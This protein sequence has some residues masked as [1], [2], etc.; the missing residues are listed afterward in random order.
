MFAADP[1]APLAG[2]PLLRWAFV[3]LTLA[4]AALFVG[5]VYWSA[6]RSNLT[7]DAA[8]RQARLAALVALAWIVATGAAAA[9]GVLKFQPPTIATVGIGVI[10]LTI[11]AARHPLGRRLAAALPLSA[12]VGFQSFRI[13]VELLLH[14][15]YTEGL[16]PVQMSYSGRNFDV[17]SGLTAAA[18]AL[19]L[20]TGRR[21]G[22]RRIVFLWNTLGVALLANILI[23]AML[24]T[25]TPLRVF[26]NEPANVWIRDWP[27]VWLPAVM[28]LA[29]IVGHVL[30]YQRLA[31]ESRL[32]HP[33]VPV[34]GDATEVRTAS[35]AR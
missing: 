10:A 29:A 21:S 32:A 15:A 8:A 3:A 22:T 28:V 1:T 18:L 11:A 14:R 13:L 2:S 23:V 19:W 7:G 26:D 31:M 17:V 35:G 16:M 9:T 27:W 6:R 12:L 33:D 25:P 5:G 30:V 24:S 4:L 34:P 20:A